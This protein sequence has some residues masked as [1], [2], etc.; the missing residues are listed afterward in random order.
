MTNFKV[1][2]AKREQ[3]KLRIALSGVSGSGKTEGALR[4]ATGIGGNI[5]VIDTEDRRSLYCADRFQFQHIEF[6]PPFSPESYIEAIEIAE[7]I[8]EVIIIDSLSHEWEGEGGLLEN[9]SNTPGNAFVAWKPVTPR[10][11]RLIEK[12]KRCK[13]HIICTLR[14]KEAYEIVDEGGKKVPKKMGLKPI[15]REGMSYEFT[16][17]LNLDISHKATGDND[18]TGLFP[19]NDWQE[20]TINTGK[21]LLEWA[22][23]GE[24]YIPPAP[25]SPPAKPQYLT[26]E[27]IQKLLNAFAEFGVTKAD[28]EKRIEVPI[29]EITPAIKANL[30]AIY[31]EISGAF[32]KTPD[33][34]F[35]HF[36]KDESAPGDPLPDPADEYRPGSLYY[37]LKEIKRVKD[38]LKKATGTDDAY[39]AEIAGYQIEEAGALRPCKKS[40]EITPDFRKILLEKLQQILAEAKAEKPQDTLV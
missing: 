5:C 25:A 36:P 24:V 7:D 3:L 14:S 37:L 33:I 2:E 16:V 38:A 9:V 40:K 22:N 26:P 12:I 13:T 18:H 10:H 11:Q 20:I 4:L 21:R 29:T 30:D 28:I 31:R 15:Q 27:R 19:Y 32:A 23:S 8:A 34:V 39:Y 35:K 6:V 1:R 17:L